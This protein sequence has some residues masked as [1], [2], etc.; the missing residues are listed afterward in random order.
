MITNIMLVG[1]VVGIFALG[2]GIYLGSIKLGAA[3]VQRMPVSEKCSRTAE[4]IFSAIK[5]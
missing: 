3:L 2:F 4:K 5:F 1:I